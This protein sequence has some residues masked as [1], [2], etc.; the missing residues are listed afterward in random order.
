VKRAP[1]GP[2]PGPRRSIWPDRPL[3]PWEV[4]GLV[5]IVALVVSCCLGVVGMSLFSPAPPP[6]QAPVYPVPSTSTR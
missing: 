4:T 1:Y 3:K 2:P 5:T 6:Y